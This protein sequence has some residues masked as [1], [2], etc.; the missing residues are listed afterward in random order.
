MRLRSMGP[1]ILACA[2]LAATGRPVLG[3]DLARVADTGN[4]Q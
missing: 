3:I 2:A 1:V 4:L